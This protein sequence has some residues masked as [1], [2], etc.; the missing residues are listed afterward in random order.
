MG[1][2]KIYYYW[3]M[4]N[5]KFKKRGRP[6]GYRANNPASQKL[7]VRVTEDQL[8]KYRTTAEEK[9]TTLSDWV[10]TTLDKAAKSTE[11]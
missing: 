8:L 3:Q 9:G 10:R 11:K 2:D 4:T 7:P 1:T 5:I 6:E